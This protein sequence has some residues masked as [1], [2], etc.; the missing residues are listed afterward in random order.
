MYVVK[1]RT[2]PDLKAAIEEVEEQVLV[3]KQKREKKSRK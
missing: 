3:A 2:N 1:S